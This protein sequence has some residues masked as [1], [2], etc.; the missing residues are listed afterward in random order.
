MKRSLAERR[1]KLLDLHFA[2]GLDQE[3]VENL[4]SEYGV[5]PDTIWSDYSRRADWIP[6]LF[7]LKDAT[8]KVYELIAVLERAL[9]SAYRQMVVSEG[10]TKIGARRDVYALAGKIHE[11]TEAHGM[12]PSVYTKFL[13]E[14]AKLEEKLDAEET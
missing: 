10:P 7:V 2:G 5:S 11:I 8:G 6:D 3:N 9:T 12:T 13:E 4:A 1:L 14:L